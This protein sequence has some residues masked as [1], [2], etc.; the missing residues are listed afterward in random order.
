VREREAA[1]ILQEENVRKLQE[2]EEK[3]AA[4]KARGSGRQ[5]KAQ[6]KKAQEQLK[7]LKEEED[8]LFDCEKCSMRGRRLVCSLCY[9]IHAHMAN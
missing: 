3:I 4:G 2:E 7:K 1:K 6:M 9:D 5:L 8:W